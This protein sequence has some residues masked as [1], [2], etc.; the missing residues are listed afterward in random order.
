[1]TPEE[2]A[3]RD[4]IAAWRASQGPTEKWLGCDGRV[5]EIAVRDAEDPC[6]VC[7]RD[8]RKHRLAWHLL[9]DCGPDEP[10]IHGV[11]YHC[12]AE[13]PGYRERGHDVG[14]CYEEP[15]ATPARALRL[16][17]VLDSQG[18]HW[19]TLLSQCAWLRGGIVGEP[20]P[21]S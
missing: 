3:F 16:R 12:G 5:H 2:Q 8:W 6:P 21:T 11:C 19:L 10:T 15:R 9:P 7:G 20:S 14:K 17:L 13:D 1:M 18:P 4:T